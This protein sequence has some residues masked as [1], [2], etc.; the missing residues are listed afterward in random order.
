MK[1][2]PFVVGLTGGI[3]SGKSTAA[4]LFVELGAG[5]VDT[6]AI[7]HALTGANG[8]AMPALIAAFGADIAAGDGSL[9]R[10]EMRR[11]AFSDPALKKR[12]ES[13][14]HPMIRSEAAKA[15]AASSQPY[16]LYAI[17]LLAESGGRAL[18]ALDRVLL[19][20]CPETLQCERAARRGSLSREEV[21]SII[22][23]QAS[24]AERLELADDVLDNSGEESS[25][26]TAVRALHERYLD[27]AREKI[28]D[29]L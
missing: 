29:G 26:L 13:I 7:A 9:A 21:W 25:L 8:K 28:S 20:D 24:R 15:I 23:N 4:R 10:L 12:L 1:L 5:L 17:P 11:R 22:N 6:D 27:L 16:L 18:Y 19:I 3:G 2:S 14:L